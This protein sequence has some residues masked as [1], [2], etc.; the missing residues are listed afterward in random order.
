MIEKYKYLVFTA[1]FAALS[2]CASGPSQLSQYQ[3]TAVQSAAQQG[4]SDMNCPQAAGTVLSSYLA[5][6]VIESG[7]QHA[8][9]TVNVEGCGQSRKYSVTCTVGDNYCTAVAQ[10]K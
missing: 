6:P 9:Y 5:E 2:G 1:L 7:N 8:T 10:K 4:Q 3:A